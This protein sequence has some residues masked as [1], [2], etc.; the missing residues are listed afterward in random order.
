MVLLTLNYSRMA[1]GSV[2]QR[3]AHIKT[4]MHCIPQHTK[5]QSGDSLIYKYQITSYTGNTVSRHSMG[6]PEAP[7][8][9]SYCNLKPFSF[10]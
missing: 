5:P 3:Q 4:R 10:Y 1:P 6:K 7:P 9:D 2:S 8:G